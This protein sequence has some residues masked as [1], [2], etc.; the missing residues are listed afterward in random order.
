MKTSRPA[1]LLIS[2]L[3][4]GHAVGGS[5]RFES[6]GEPVKIRTLSFCAVTQDPD[7]FS[8]G[9]APFLEDG[10]DRMALVGVRT[11]TGAVIWNDLSK[12][13]QGKVTLTQGNDGNVY[14]YAGAPGH[15]FRY[16]IVR[17]EL[18]DL[19]MPEDAASYY[20]WGALGPDGRFYVGTYPNAALVCC[21][22]RTGKIE[23]LGRLSPD[24]RESY[25]YPSVAISDDNIVYCPVG[26]HHMELWACNAR[27][28]A[29][30]QILPPALTELQGSPRVWTGT[31]GRVYGSAGETSFL[32]L[33][34]RIEP[35]KTIPERSAPLLLAGGK[36]LG[37]I[38]EEGKLSLTD[39]KTGKRTWLQTQFEG[40]RAFIFSVGCERGGR[41]YGSCALPSRSFSYDTATGKLTDLGILDSGKC[42][43]YDTI[44]QPEGL[45]LA[46][47]FGAHVDLYDPDK[48]LEPD[49]NP[50]HLGSAP[51]QERP[52]QWCLGPE[53]M[54]YT[55]TEPAKGRLGGALLRVN[56]KDLSLKM[57]P[58]PIRN[59]SIEYVAA[60]PETGELLC[61]TSIEGGSSAIPT[62][63]EACVFLWDTKKE[64]MV[65]RAEPIR[66][67]KT[68]G[69]AVRARNGL[70]YGVGG[71]K[72]YA[73]D[74]KARAFIFTGSL[75][76]KR[77][78][79]PGLNDE[80]VGPLGLIYG[81]GDDAVFAIA[82][83]DHSARVV[84]R[85]PSISG[86]GAGAWG[87]SGF[88][89][90]LEGVLYYGSGATLM[91]CRLEN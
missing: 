81:L 50:R 46:S 53:G 1:L 13:R 77:L 8:V 25:I 76:V 44:S 80:P 87:A 39:P 15:F 7:G 51:G 70:I 2:S 45:F 12:Y 38:N 72:Y 57:W 18:Q 75:P 69:R 10:L 78:H 16:D 6:L 9:W 17:R 60:I 27:T 52:I 19:G 83:A 49:K 33:G 21:D 61:T 11:D 26:L 31:D 55:G 3:F 30:K 63:N 71:R 79:F 90:T 91:R 85:D 47:Y 42:E 24:N 4:V 36:L 68:Y 74:P 88:F 54:L 37:A 32:C 34:E 59:Q 82:P 20:A 64:A 84:A 89:V 48:P 29:R 5:Y 23:N 35:G 40:S 58:T 28:G 41:I 56:P 62:E 65:F 67:T 22:T 73:F 86:S 43:V 14:V 66:G